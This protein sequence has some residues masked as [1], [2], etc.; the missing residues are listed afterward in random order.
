M[1][2]L[3]TGE[4]PSPPSTRNDILL[5]S[6]GKIC[7]QYDVS[8]TDPDV[9]DWKQGAMAVTLTVS[10]TVGFVDLGFPD[11]YWISVRRR[12]PSAQHDS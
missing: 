7:M 4:V 8:D 5:D 6:D 10:N 11:K 3:S 1:I 2:G 12:Y 9:G